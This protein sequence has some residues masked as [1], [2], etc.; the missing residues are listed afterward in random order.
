MIV[1]RNVWNIRRSINLS[2]VGGCRWC[3]VSAVEW[4]PSDFWF[5]ALQLDCEVRT[6]KS[7]KTICWWRHSCQCP[8]HWNM[9]YPARDRQVCG[10]DD[11]CSFHENSTFQVSTLHLRCGSQLGEKCLK[12]SGVWLSV[13]DQHFLVS[14]V[15]LSCVSLCPPQHNLFIHVLCVCFTS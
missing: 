2:H 5:A 3:D 14:S 8:A 13:S 6:N 7:T 1:T 12:L 15:V 11:A 4:K 10:E 9:K